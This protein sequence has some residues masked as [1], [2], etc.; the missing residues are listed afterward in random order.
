MTTLHP[1]N[2]EPSKKGPK[3]ATKADA[4]TSPKASASPPNGHAAEPPTL[5]NLTK[6]RI[7]DALH[8]E[9]GANGEIRVPWLDK[10]FTVVL[11]FD[12]DAPR[13]RDHLYG[14]TFRFDDVP[15]FAQPSPYEALTY[16][17]ALLGIK[18]PPTEE[19]L[20][21]EEVMAK[22]ADK[23]TARAGADEDDPATRTMGTR[24]ANSEEPPPFDEELN[25]TYAFDQKEMFRQHMLSTLGYAPDDIDDDGEFHGFS[26][27]ENG[28]GSAGYYAYHDDAIQPYGVFGDHRR[29]DEIYKWSG[30]KANLSPDQQKIC[31]D[32]RDRRLRELKEKREEKWRKGR[33]KHKRSGIR[34]SPPTLT[35]TTCKRKRF[36]LMAFAKANAFMNADNRCLFRF[37]ATAKSSRCKTSAATN[38]SS[39]TPRSRAATS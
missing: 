28:K 13:D 5:D 32:L 11:D 19:E 21:A 17:L 18:V 38:G 10:S 36:S 30:S 31:D 23:D 37:G 8:V 15:S 29:G 9:I 2:N 6:Q 24:K 20:R 14:F 3:A 4:K 22:G 7:A 1:D 25:K 34:R 35:I 27:K 12:P 33:R 39:P 26:T 16:A